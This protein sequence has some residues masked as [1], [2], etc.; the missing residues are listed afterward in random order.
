MLR[1]SETPLLPFLTRHNLLATFLRLLH[2]NLAQE[3]KIVPLRQL[4]KQPAGRQRQG[5]GGGVGGRAHATDVRGHGMPPYR[6]RRDGGRA[7]ER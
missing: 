1:C 7:G 4:L 3:F 2:P 6:K 5:Y